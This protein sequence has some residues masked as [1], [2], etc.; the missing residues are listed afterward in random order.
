MKKTITIILGV[1]ALFLV[2]A[3][4]GSSGDNTNNQTQTPAQSPTSTPTPTYTL[5]STQNVTS[6]SVPK[7]SIQTEQQM[8]SQNSVQ[9][10]TPVVSS[11]TVSDSPSQTEQITEPVPIEL[12]GTGQKAT[13]KFKLEQGLSEFS[14]KYRG[15]SNFIVWLVD[16]ET[17][18]NVE[19]LAN[20]IGS[21]DG[22]KAVGI[23][24]DGDY[25][26]NV[27]A[28]GPWT[29]IITQPRQSP[30]QS[31]PLTLQGTGQQ[32]SELF[33]LDYGLKTFEMNYRGASNFIVWLMDDQ[34]N[35]V[36][37]LANEIGSFNGSKAIGI[38]QTGT[39]LLDVQAD[40]KW[41][42]SV[43]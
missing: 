11:T 17:G 30:T 39:Y 32:A 15:S 34:G 10:S 7:S 29:V 36:D 3:M 23:T 16:G 35:R 24:A 41:E 1:V 5:E 8:E 18:Q 38:P 2:L 33:T 43:K 12:S 26:L 19:L 9:E 31:A 40:G 4:L 20:E 6:T 14:M 27:Q 22:S 13:Q 42:I 37:L 25:I 21:F 28:D